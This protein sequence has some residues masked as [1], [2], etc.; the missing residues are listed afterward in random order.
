MPEIWGGLAKA[1]NDNERIEEAISRHTA[2]HNADETSHLLPG[3]SLQSHKASA[4]IDHLARSIVTDKLAD[5]AITNEKIADLAVTDIKIASLSANKITAGTI[6]A[7]TINV[8]NL[9]ADNLTTGSLT[10]RTISTAPIGNFR[11]VMS[12]YTEFFRPNSITSYN[13]AGTYLA[14]IEFASNG[15]LRIGGEYDNGL[16]GDW[17]IG[18]GLRPATDNLQGLGT[19][20]FAFGECF[21]GQTR[22]RTLFPATDNTFDLGFSNM[23]WRNLFLSNQLTV[24]GHAFFSGDLITRRIYPDGDNT[25]TSGDPSRR[26]SIVFTNVLNCTTLIRPTTDLTGS[27]GTWSFRFLSIHAHHFHASGLVE[28]AKITE[29]AAGGM[30]PVNGSMFYDITNHRVRVMINGV[31]R[32]ITTTT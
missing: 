9:N 13:A 27:V 29:T 6:D 23:R 18:D 26:W 20:T 19:W 17:Y 7:A 28:L 32:T 21:L 16:M 22:T 30:S 3:Q 25:R 24:A 14:S 8:I 11:L 15:D 31:W 12:S 10:G 2:E 1:Q 4:I 5:F